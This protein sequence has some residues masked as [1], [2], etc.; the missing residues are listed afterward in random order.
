LDCPAEWVDFPGATYVEHNGEAEV[1]PGIRLLPTPATRLATRA[2]SSIR[3]TALIIVGG[4]V[5]YTF[6]EM[7]SSATEGQTLAGERKR[8]NRSLRKTH[9]LERAI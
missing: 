1:L 6:Q 2:S 3:P 4:D 5:A 8:L 7:G 9:W